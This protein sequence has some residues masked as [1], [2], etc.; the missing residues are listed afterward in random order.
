MKTR[1]IAIS[2]LA[3]AAM[4]TTSCGDDFLEVTN[5][6]GDF[7]EDYYKSD[8]HLQ[9]ALIAAYDPIHWPDWG[10]FTRTLNMPFSSAPPCPMNR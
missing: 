9:E 7:L 4:L 5:P 3:A 2:L 6:N 1:N 8:E 10:P